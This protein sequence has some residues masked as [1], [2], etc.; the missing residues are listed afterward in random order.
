LQG[1]HKNVFHRSVKEIIHVHFTSLVGGT[2]E[3]SDDVSYELNEVPV[4]ATQMESKYDE[5]DE[6]ITSLTLEDFGL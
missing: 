6:D 1:W 5:D 4:P 3:S 2:S